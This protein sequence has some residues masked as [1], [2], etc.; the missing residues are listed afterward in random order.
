[1]DQGPIV[2]VASLLHRGRPKTL[3]RVMCSPSKIGPLA[4]LPPNVGGG[5]GNGLSS[6]I[7]KLQEEQA[8][9][10]GS[11]R[12]F[13]TLRGADFAVTLP[14]AIS[15]AGCVQRDTAHRV[16]DGNGALAGGHK[17]FTAESTSL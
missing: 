6:E 3:H 17:Q 8:S 5:V 2:W 7:R 1:M 13:H 16:R 12:G 10:C 15:Q 14:L 4:P 9:R 11:V